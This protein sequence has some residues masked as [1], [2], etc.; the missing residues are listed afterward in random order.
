MSFSV[1]YYRRYSRDPPTEDQFSSPFSKTSSL[2]SGLYVFPTNPQLVHFYPSFPQGTSS[3]SYTF[4]TKM[5]PPSTT[6]KSPDLLPTV[7]TLPLSSS[8]HPPRALLRPTVSGPSGTGPET[9]FSSPFGNSTELD[10]QPYRSKRKGFSTSSD[11]TPT[12]TTSPSSDRTPDRSYEDVLSPLRTP[13][14]PDP[15]TVV[16][17]SFPVLTSY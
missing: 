13:P 4:L 14:E 6:H 17:T 5:V 10:P 11:G 3:L 16:C 8:S 1:F 7:L 2:W 15:T 9:V 12:R